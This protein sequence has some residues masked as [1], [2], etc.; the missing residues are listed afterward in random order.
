MSVLEHSGLSRAG[1]LPICAKVF[2]LARGHHLQAREWIQRRGHR[3][4]SVKDSISMYC[5]YGAPFIDF[6]RYESDM[7]SVSMELLIA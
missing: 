2:A 4:C 1:R 7:M 6:M 5:T 3:M